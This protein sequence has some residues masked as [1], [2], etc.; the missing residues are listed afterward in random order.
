MSDT[1]DLYEMGCVVR[2]QTEWVKLHVNHALGRI[3]NFDFNAAVSGLLLIYGKELLSELDEM[4]N[5]LIQKE[6]QM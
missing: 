6:K 3:S 4:I 2:A 1:A 5:D